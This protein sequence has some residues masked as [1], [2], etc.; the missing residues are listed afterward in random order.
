MLYE[1]I[2]TA[3]GSNMATM[4]TMA[5]KLGVRAFDIRTCLPE[6]KR[7][8]FDT[9]LGTD[10]DYANSLWPTFSSVVL[11]HNQA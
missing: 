8:K 10:N 3:T 1:L 11:T 9:R 6:H 7:V 4:A 5:T 2:H